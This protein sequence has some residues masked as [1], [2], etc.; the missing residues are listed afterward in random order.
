MDD[1]A[2]IGTERA[3]LGANS[4]ESGELTTIF[5]RRKLSLTGNKEES[6]EEAELETGCEVELARSCFDSSLVSSN[7][8]GLTEEDSGIGVCLLVLILTK[9]KFEGI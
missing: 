6:S 4:G 7:T 9:G 1:E 5:L 8:P 2:I 3:I